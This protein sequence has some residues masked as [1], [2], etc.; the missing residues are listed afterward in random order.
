MATPLDDVCGA[1]L[2]LTALVALAEVRCSPYVEVAIVE[3]RAWVRWPSDN[4]EML[5]RLLPVRGAELFCCRGGLWYRFGSRLPSPGWPSAAAVKPLHHILI[6]APVAAE[7]REEDAWRRCGLTLVREERPRLATALRSDLVELGRWAER[8]TS[9][10]LTALEGA[11]CQEKVLVR[12]GV[13]PPMLR[14]ER[15]WGSRVL[16]PLGYRAE[17]ALPEGGLLEALGADESE[18]AVLR[19]GDAE[20]VPAGAFAP[21]TRAGVRLAVR[22]VK[23]I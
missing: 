19:D 15:Y 2:P 17:P 22:A 10:Q 5:R 1:C 4:E 6:P 18:V 11:V 7:P 14:A 23:D 21:L 16:T 8:A 20:L 13:L 3:D 12:G 9:A